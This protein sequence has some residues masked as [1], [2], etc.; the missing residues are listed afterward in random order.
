MSHERIKQHLIKAYGIQDFP[1]EFLEA[2][3]RCS[4]LARDLV[5]NKLSMKHRGPKYNKQNRLPK[6]VDTYV[7]RFVA[8]YSNA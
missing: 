5:V 4:P 8:R 3:A 6:D 2:F 7:E 1:E